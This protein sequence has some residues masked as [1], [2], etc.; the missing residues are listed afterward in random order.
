MA[1]LS[2]KHD[3]FTLSLLNS[4]LKQIGVPAFV[5]SKHHLPPS[6]SKQISLQLSLS[7]PNKV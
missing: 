4:K 1:L 3:Y 6:K 7:L 2:L 5:A